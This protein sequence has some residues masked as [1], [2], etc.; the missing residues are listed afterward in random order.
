M[1]DAIAFGW[2][3]Y[4]VAAAC[5][6]IAMLLFVRSRTRQS[7]SLLQAEASEG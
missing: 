4:V 3:F 5:L 2:V 7:S 1:S 6:I